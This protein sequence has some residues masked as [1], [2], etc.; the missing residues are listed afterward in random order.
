MWPGGCVH[1]GQG[2]P[3]QRKQ[4]QPGTVFPHQLEGSGSCGNVR[5][6]RAGLRAPVRGSTAVVFAPALPS[7][8]VSGM[9]HL[10]NGHWLVPWCRQV[11]TARMAA[12]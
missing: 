8:H 11:V 9:W 3:Y 4:S 12:A 10:G 7:P 5:F 2:G 6:Q 1:G